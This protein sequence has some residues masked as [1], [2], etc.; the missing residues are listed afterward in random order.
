[1][2]F[3]ALGTREKEFTHKYLTR[4]DCVKKQQLEAKSILVFLMKKAPNEPSLREHKGEGIFTCK[5]RKHEK[6]TRVSPRDEER[7]EKDPWRMIL[8]GKS[9]FMIRFGDPDSCS[10]DPNGK[11]V[12]ISDPPKKSKTRYS[13]D[14]RFIFLQLAAL[15]LQ[16]I[17]RHIHSGRRFQTNTRQNKQLRSITDCLSDSNRKGN[18]RRLK[19]R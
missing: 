9:L 4:P 18:V 16:C 15:P 10:S 2:A 17:K 6:Y 3:F 1:M 8:R 7:R 5:T 11:D 14:Q 12:L 13:K 19:F